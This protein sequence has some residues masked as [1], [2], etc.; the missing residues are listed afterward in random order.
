LYIKKLI[1]FFII[2]AI[3]YLLYIGLYLKGYFNPKEIYIG[4]IKID[5]PNNM[6]L[7]EYKLK[8]KSRLKLARD[9]AFIA[10]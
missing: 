4:N 5:I 8:G 6:H 9:K 2:L 3:S 7:V 1:I 10:N